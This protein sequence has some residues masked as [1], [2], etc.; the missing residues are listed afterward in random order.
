MNMALP[1]VAEAANLHGGFRKMVLL[2][3]PASAAGA[4]RGPG[5]SGEGVD[6]TCP[7]A[8][9]CGLPEVVRSEVALLLW[10]RSCCQDQLRYREC[11]RFQLAESG[12]PVP[13]GLL[14][15]GYTLGVP[16]P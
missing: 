3:G 2:A 13:A 7:R 11:R 15:N 9:L 16:Q 12:R 8:E 1:P 10:Q 6:M 5:A 4:R 14:P